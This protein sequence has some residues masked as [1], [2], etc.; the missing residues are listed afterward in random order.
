MGTLARLELVIAKH[1]RRSHWIEEGRA[2]KM[3]MI[4][5]SFVTPKG[6]NIVGRS[7]WHDFWSKRLGEEWYWSVKEFAPA[8]SIWNDREGMG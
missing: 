3:K 4:W 6:G 1:A 8:C 5:T 2:Y 7:I